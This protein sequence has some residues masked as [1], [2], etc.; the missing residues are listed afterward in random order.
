L[1][2]PAL[3]S[4]LHAFVSHPKQLI[5]LWSKSDSVINQAKAISAGFP[6]TCNPFTT[7]NKQT[8]KNI[9]WELTPG[10]NL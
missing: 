5:D 4:H 3:E 6:S 1:G 10:N 8:K 9:M 2:T 7:K